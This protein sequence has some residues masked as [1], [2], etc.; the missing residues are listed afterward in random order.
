MDNR[1]LQAIFDVV[2]RSQGKGHVSIVELGSGASTLILA[3]VLPRVVENPYITAVEGE[4]AYARQTQEMLRQ[5]KLDRYANVSWVPYALSDDRI[6]FSKPELEQVMFEKRV[7]VLIVDAPPGSLQP[8]A[9][10][11]AIPFFLPYFKESS[12]V[13]LHDSSRPDE[14][15]I[16]KEWKRYFRVCYEITTPRG[17]AVFERCCQ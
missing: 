7:D 17:L 9:R 2:C 5:H 11:P 3:S 16:A 13:M 6:W 10:Q 15:L 8:R 4:E 1:D 12:V 14:S